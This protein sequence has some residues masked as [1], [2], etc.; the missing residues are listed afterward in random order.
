MMINGAIA[1]P[2][3]T[4]A[5]LAI[6]FEDWQ[7]MWGRKPLSLWTGTVVAK[8]VLFVANA[9]HSCLDVS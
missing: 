2:W 7:E 4:V 9:S 6:G 8:L 3:L 5:S 1:L